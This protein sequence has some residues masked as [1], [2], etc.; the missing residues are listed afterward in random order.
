MCGGVYL[1]GRIG[2]VRSGER[3]AAQ[4]DGIADEAFLDLP[5]E[6]LAAALIESDKAGAG[7]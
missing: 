1:N 7:R 5:G 4:H 6:L 3:A 2:R